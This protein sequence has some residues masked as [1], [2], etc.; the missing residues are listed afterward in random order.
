[1]GDS[2]F[3]PDCPLCGEQMVERTGPKIKFYGCIRYP[4]C[5]GK[6]TLDGVAFGIDGEKPEAPAWLDK[7]GRECFYAGLADGMSYEEAREMAFD[8]QRL[9]E[10]DR[11]N[12]R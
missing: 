2:D 10:K 6:R 5:K 9:E 7:E 8:W 3:A 11:F 1:M 4:L 12:E